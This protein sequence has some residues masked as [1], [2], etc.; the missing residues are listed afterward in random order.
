MRRAVLGLGM[1]AVLLIP[2]QASERDPF[3]RGTPWKNHPIL[4]FAGTPLSIHNSE[5]D[6]KPAGKVRDWLSS[7]DRSKNDCHVTDTV[8]GKQM[9]IVCVRRGLYGSPPHKL[10]FVYQASVIGA[11][12][13]LINFATTDGTPLLGRDLLD[14]FRDEI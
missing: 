8:P 6:A 5:G 4:S 9:W 11:G 10:V 14:H 1:A 12:Y 3:S 7:Y 2:A 13:V